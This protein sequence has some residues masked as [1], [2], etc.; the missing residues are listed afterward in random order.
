MS[1]AKQTKY[2]K[3]VVGVR[4]VSGIYGIT[5]DD[6]VVYVGKAKIMRKRAIG[7]IR[8]AL[9]GHP[10]AKYQLLSAAIKSE[11]H[12]VLVIELEECA[13]KELSDLEAKLISS[14]KNLPLNTQL[15]KSTQKPRE[16]REEDFF[17]NLSVCK[18]WSPEL[19]SFIDSK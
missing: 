16:L 1:A 19:H 11:C 14:N 3:Y 8:N 6:F 17:K 15:S 18:K 12:Q 7:H 13:I 10:R 4:K 2:D 5:V 9:K